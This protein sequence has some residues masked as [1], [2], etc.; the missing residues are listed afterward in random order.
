MFE[1]T[2]LSDGVFGSTTT[3]LSDLPYL[4]TLCSVSGFSCS[5]PTRSNGLVRRQLKVWSRDN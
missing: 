1:I 5:K 4:L 2:M 3:V